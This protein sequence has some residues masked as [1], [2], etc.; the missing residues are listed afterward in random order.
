MKTLL[1]SQRIFFRTSLL[2]YKKPSLFKA[3]NIGLEK[4]VYT[5]SEAK[6][7]PPQKVREVVVE[8][9]RLLKERGETV[10]VA[11][12]AA[13][14]IVSASILSTPGASK[15]FK[16][17]LTVYTL[18]SRI[19]FAGWTQE[20]IA[21]YNGPTPD[22]VAGIAENVREKLGSTY[23]ICESGTAG[24]GASGKGAN[25]QPGYVALAIATEK[26]THKK[27]LNTGLGGDRE[28]NM[29]V[30]A[31]EALGYLRDVLKGDAKI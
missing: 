10:S 28:G 18:E 29:I 13:G 27:D 7:F 26:G 25:R 24:P 16:G 8:V 5:M 9:T 20:N 11:E 31:T 23:C 6:E 30:F 3:Q 19:A 14:G 1:L 15:V 21:A 12:T 4:S 2:F 22:L 17:G